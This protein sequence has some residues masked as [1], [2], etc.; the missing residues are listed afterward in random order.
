MRSQ[1]ALGRKLL[2]G[3]CTACFDT[4]VFAVRDRV[5]SGGGGNDNGTGDRGYPRLEH[6]MNDMESSGVEGGEKYMAG[7]MVEYVL[8]KLRFGRSASRV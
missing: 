6:F 7:G 4:S 2:Q 1:V 3:L 8:V 5:G